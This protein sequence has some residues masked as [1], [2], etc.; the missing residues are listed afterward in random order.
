MEISSKLGFPDLFVTFTCNLAWPEISRVS[1]NTTLMA[2]DRPYIITRL[3][4]MKF[5]EL[6]TDV[7]KSHVPGKVLAF[8]YTIEF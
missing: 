5:D 8:I 1:S 2:H 3:F 6:V 4:K 7:T